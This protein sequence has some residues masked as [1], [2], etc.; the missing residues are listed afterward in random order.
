MYIHC[1]LY[2][3]LSNI[4]FS[5]FYVRPRPHEDEGAF[6]KEE[7]TPSHFATDCLRGLSLQKWISWAMSLGSGG[8]LFGVLLVILAGS[9]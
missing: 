1:I 2:S 7:A 5:M 4:L 8:R 3:I 6:K 9:L